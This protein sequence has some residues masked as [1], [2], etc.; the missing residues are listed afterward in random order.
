MATVR[1]INRLI[2][3]VLSDI[4][5]VCNP[6]QPIEAEDARTVKE[7]IQDRLAAWTGVITIPVVTTESFSMVSGTASYTIGEDGSP[8]LD[9]VRPDQIVG[10]YIKSN[11]LDSS[12]R[13][14]TENQYRNIADKTTS[15]QPTRAFPDYK[16]PNITLFLYP[17]PDTTDRIYIASIKTYTEPTQLNDDTFVD[18]GIPGVV[19][20]ALKWRIA[21]DVAP[22]LP[23]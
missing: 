11:G 19:Y 2:R 1:T 7:A 10:A 5:G 13:I 17:V 12:V 23:C 18:L 15:G 20:N 4:L 3:A 14:I 21:I 22:G 16:T 8:S 9:T 6:A